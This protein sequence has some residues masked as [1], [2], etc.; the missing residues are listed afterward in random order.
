[1]QHQLSSTDAKKRAPARRQWWQ[2]AAFAALLT[3]ACVGGAA[4]AFGVTDPALHAA[5]LVDDT[6]APADDARVRTLLTLLDVS[7]T[8]AEMGPL[9]A[10][11]F[12]L[13]LT[14]ENPELNEGVAQSFRQALLDVL[15]GDLSDND[16][17]LWRSYLDLYK[18]NFSAAEVDDLIAFYSSKTGRK[19]LKQ[20]QLL[21]EESG[22]VIQAWVYGAKDRVILRFEELMAQRSLDPAAL[23]N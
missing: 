17:R 4:A 19:Y 23:P 7:T 18:R 22:L 2:T 3:T 6:A 21:F 8:T 12:A 14:E 5:G 10:E 16:S 15:G 9:I 13:T 11:Q 1:M 20:Q